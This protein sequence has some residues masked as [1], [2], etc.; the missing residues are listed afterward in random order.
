MG[1]KSIIFE[2]HKGDTT[3]IVDS[4]SKYVID[5][6]IRDAGL[7]DRDIYC[8][9]LHCKNKNYDNCLTAIINLAK[10]GIDIQR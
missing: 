8:V 6:N 10:D 5:L 1:K 2:I 7:A 3:S 9:W 4:L